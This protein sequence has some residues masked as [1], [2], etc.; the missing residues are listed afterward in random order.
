LCVLKKL[1]KLKIGGVLVIDNIDWYMPNDEN[2]SP[3]SKRTNDTF[4]S[5][6][7]ENV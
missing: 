2:H 6:D 3:S 4:T 1:P 7:W 5:S